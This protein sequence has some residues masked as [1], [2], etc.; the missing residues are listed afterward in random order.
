MSIQTGEQRAKGFETDL[1]WEP[2]RAVSVLFNYAWTDAEVTADNA[3]PVGDALPRIPE[4]SGRIAARYRV[5]D[6]A[7]KGLSFGAGCHRAGRS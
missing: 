4:H 3:P 1:I 5:L 2:T 6:G 7:A